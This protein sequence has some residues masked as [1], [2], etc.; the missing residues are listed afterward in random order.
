MQYQYISNL[1]SLFWL[2]VHNIRIYPCYSRQL[3][4]LQRNSIIK[5]SFRK[6]FSLDF[7]FKPFIS[8]KS[9]ILSQVSITKLIIIFS[10]RIV[11]PTEMIS[12]N[13][14]GFHFGGR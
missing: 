12:K 8:A 1:F 5:H 4:L 13:S 3:S 10:H 7:L 11:D 9:L 14:V 6:I 2:V